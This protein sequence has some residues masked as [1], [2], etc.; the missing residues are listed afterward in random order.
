VIPPDPTAREDACNCEVWI[1]K[2]QAWTWRNGKAS[3]TFTCPVHGTITIDNREIPASIINT[4][5]D[6]Q[7]T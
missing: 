5:D 2:I 7:E 1:S 3:T 4:S 6:E